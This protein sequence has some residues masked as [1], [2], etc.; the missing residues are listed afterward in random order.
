MEKTRKI[1][2][3]SNDFIPLI[4]HHGPIYNP[5]NVSEVGVKQ[6]QALGVKIEFADVEPV[7]PKK[8]QPVPEVKLEVKPPVSEPEVKAE[9]NP[10]SSALD[11]L[12]FEPVDGVKEEVVVKHEGKKRR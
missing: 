11:S 2:I 3:L 8:I 6:L 9:L 4:G 5:I 10:K 12:T 1:R 7:K